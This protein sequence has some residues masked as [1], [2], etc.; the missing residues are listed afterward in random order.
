MYKKWFIKNKKIAT[1]IIEALKE[2]YEV[3]HAIEEGLEIV[4][5]F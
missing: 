3:E 4:K 1:P 2:K 5:E